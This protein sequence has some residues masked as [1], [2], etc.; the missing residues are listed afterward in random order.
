MRQA[1]AKN[2]EADNTRHKHDY[3]CS[4][5]LTTFVVTLITFVVTV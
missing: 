1:E 2:G 5:S 4:H 3:V